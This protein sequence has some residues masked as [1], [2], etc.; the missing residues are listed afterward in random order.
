MPT[1][2][3]NNFAIDRIL[4][5]VFSSTKDGTVLCNMTQIQNA[6]LNVTS[7]TADVVDALGTP[8]MTFYR[9]KTCEFSAESALFDLNL[10]ALQSGTTKTIASGTDKIVSPAMETLKV[11]AAHTI[12]LS[13]TPAAEPQVVYTVNGDSSFGTAYTKNTTA[14]GTNFSLADTTITL[15]DEV[16]EGTTIFVMYDYETARGV[17]VVNTATNFPGTCKFTMQVLGYNVCDQ[18]T[19]IMAY[20]IFPNFKVSPDFDWSIASDG[21]HPFSGTAQQDYC[22]EEKR[23][24]AIVIP[25]PEADA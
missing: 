9:A 25:D 16:T 6:S 4:R 12:T 21:V 23:L 24:F 19:K 13:H 8:I 10:L 14:T 3:I 1:F 7:E 15:P 18:E 17:E 11:S 5:G 20:V 2:D 22:D